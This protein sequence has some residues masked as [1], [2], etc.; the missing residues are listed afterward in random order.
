MELMKLAKLSKKEKKKKLKEMLAAQGG[1]DSSSSSSS[2]SSS[3]DDDSDSDSDSSSSSSR[4]VTFQNKNN[5]TKDII[6]KIFHRGLSFGQ[7]LLVVPCRFSM[8]VS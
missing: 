3:S 4:Y 5:T 2:D 8:L 6:S 1:S 7:L